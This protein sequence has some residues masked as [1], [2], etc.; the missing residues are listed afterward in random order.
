MNIQDKWP[1][2]PDEFLRWNQGREGKREFVHGRVVELMINVTRNHANLANRLLFALTSQ[3]GTDQYMI[4][5][6]DFGV[7]TAS[8][9]RFPDVIVEA[10]GGDGKALA[11]AEPLLVAEILS[12]ASMRDDFGPKAD[13]YLAIASLEHYLVIAQDTPRIWLWA[14]D[15]EG[16]FGE[17]VICDDPK[18]PVELDG[19][20]VGLDLA[21]LY[22]GIAETQG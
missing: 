11:T 3:L 17:P 16:R 19:L 1:T 4:G 8:G 5:S 9:I 21:A 6:A 13:E 14:R 7:R 18:T 20:G 12:P 10:A 15:D 22:K 2:T